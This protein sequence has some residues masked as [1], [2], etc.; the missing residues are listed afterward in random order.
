MKKTI[1]ILTTIAFFAGCED[2]GTAPGP[3]LQTKVD[4]L[5]N[6]LQKVTA[7][8]EHMPMA[9]MSQM[10]EDHIRLNSKYMQ[11]ADTRPGLPPSAKVAAIEGNPGVAGA[12]TMRGKMPSK[13]KI[14]PHTHPGD[15]HVTVL[16]GTAYMG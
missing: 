9:D 13:Y 3:N 12:F 8:K 5:Q 7:E 16:E 10:T 2:A 11:W 1:L 4:S 6:E 14:M 15:E